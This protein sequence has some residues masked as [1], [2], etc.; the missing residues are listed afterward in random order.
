MRDQF[1]DLDRVFQFGREELVETAR[2]GFEYQRLAFVHIENFLNGLID[3]LEPRIALESLNLGE[4]M[5]QC[6]ENSLI[7]ET[8]LNGILAG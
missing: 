4:S 2:I 5:L 1:E 7:G 8:R 6:V 3:G